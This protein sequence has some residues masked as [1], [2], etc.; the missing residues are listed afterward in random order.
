[1][2]IFQGY[3]TR[4]G[5]LYPLQT[6]DKNRH[7]DFGHLPLF[8]EAACPSDAQLLEKIAR[9]L[10]D[11]VVPLSSDKRKYL[12]LAAVFACN[13]SNH[14]YGIA[15]EILEE[16]AI[17]RRLLLPLIEE[18]AAKI[19]TLTP[20]EAQTGP[21]VRYDTAVIDAQIELLHGHPHRQ[22]LYRMLSEDI[23]R[24]AESNQ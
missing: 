13:F 8:I 11:T 18:T 10:S 7:T 23:H 3:T 4:C 12:H 19:R 1:M 6:M 20:R 22:M 17:D 5:V 16:Q 14:L 15:S 9:T 24:T 21:A 2:T